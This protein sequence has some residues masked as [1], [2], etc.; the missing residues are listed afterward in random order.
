VYLDFGKLE[1]NKIFEKVTFFPRWGYT[2]QWVKLRVEEPL[3]TKGLACGG[4]SM[5]N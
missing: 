1:E 4:D 5:N 2:R 3:R